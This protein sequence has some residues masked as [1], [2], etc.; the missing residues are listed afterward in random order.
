M[1]YTDAD[2]FP[3]IDIS[4]ISD[5]S[6]QESIAKEITNACQQWGFLLLKEHPIPKSE[7]Q[8]MFAL[9]REFFLQPEEDKQPWP[10]NDMNIGYIGSFKDHRKD[11][12]MSMWFGGKPGE[13]E[14]EKS[15][16]LPP[17]WHSYTARI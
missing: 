10:I 13:L 7:I 3:I 8:D 11:D 6:K 16:H 4:L 14:Q 2:S 12:K 5:P 1:E 17:F 9:S 15:Q